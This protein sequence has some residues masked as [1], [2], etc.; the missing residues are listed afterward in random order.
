MMIDS[1][2]W[3]LEDVYTRLDSKRTPKMIEILKW[4]LDKN[5]KLFKRDYYKIFPELKDIV[6]EN[7]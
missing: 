4:K 6:D 2:W 5:T 7:K 1:K 3:K